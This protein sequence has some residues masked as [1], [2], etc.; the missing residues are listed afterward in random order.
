MISDDKASHLAHLALG[1]LKK[2]AHCRLTEEDGKVLRE[3]KRVLA[4]ELTLEAEIDRKVRAKLASYSRRIVEGSS[5][6]DVM[7]RKTFEEEQ[8]KRAKP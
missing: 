7:Y 4:A 5:E 6:W 3:I 8:K 2:S 1:A